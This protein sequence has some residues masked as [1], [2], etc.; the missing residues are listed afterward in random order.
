M[1]NYYFYALSGAD[2]GISV[3][4]RKI[5]YGRG[6]GR[7]S[8]GAKSPGSL[9]NLSKKEQFE[10]YFIYIKKLTFQG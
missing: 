5:G 2:P 10:T 7:M 9:R 3:R 6:P 1:F 4:G 8:R